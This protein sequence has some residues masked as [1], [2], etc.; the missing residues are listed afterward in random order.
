LKRILLMLGAV[1]TLS[2][3]AACGPG[4]GNSP[5]FPTNT[6]G[7]TLAPTT[8]PSDMPSELPSDMP[9][10]GTESPAAS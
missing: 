6:T 8:A 10:E 9:T 3:A 2:I 4:A 7:P 1:L 5:T